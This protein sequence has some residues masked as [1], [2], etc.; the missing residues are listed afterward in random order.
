MAAAVHS[1]VSGSSSV[2]GRGHRDRDRG[3]HRV[4][5][6][7]VGAV[8]SPG[9]LGRGVREADQQAMARAVAANEGKDGNG[10]V[11]WSRS[12]A[13]SGVADETVIDVISW[14]AIR[15]TRALPT[16][17]SIGRA[18]RRRSYRAQGGAVPRDREWARST[19]VRSS[20][21]RRSGSV[22]AVGAARTRVR[23]FAR[24]AVS[25]LV[26]AVL[27]IGGP[28]CG[29][30]GRGSRARSQRCA[31]PQNPPRRPATRGR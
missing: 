23:F 16:A 21:G 13:W 22:D 8:Q 2:G 26:W 6:A 4:E 9:G 3:I 19:S 7:H 17:G 5:G 10:D 25:A 29:M 20:T 24:R 18:G 27:S 15:A 31:H 14:A 30:D 11:V 12:G 1:A 28:P